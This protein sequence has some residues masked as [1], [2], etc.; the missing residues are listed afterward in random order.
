M[1]AQ[2]TEETQEIGQI[3]DP[4]LPK[5]FPLL[6]LPYA[7]F[8]FEYQ[9]FKQRTVIFAVSFV[10][11]QG[12]AQ[13]KHISD[14]VRAIPKYPELG[15]IQWINYQLLQYPLTF[16]WYSKGVRRQEMDEETGAWYYKGK[17]SD[18]KILDQVCQYYNY[19]SVV[20]FTKRGT[21]YVKGYTDPAYKH[22]NRFY[23]YCHID[24]HEIYKKQ[25]IKFACKNK[26]PNL[27]LGTVAKALL[28]PPE[29]KYNNLTG[30]N[31]YKLPLKLL[32]DYVEQDARLVIKLV[33]NN[34][35]E[36]LD[37]MQMIANIS[38]L[39]FEQ[40]C[41][42]NISTWMGNVLSQY[43]AVEKNIRKKKYTGGHVFEPEIG[44]YESSPIFV[45][46]VKSLYPTMIINYN[47]SPETICCDCC[48]EELSSYVLDEIMQEINSLVGEKRRHCWICKR[49]GI[50]PRWLAKCR[51]ERFKAQKGSIEEKALKIILNGTYG[52]FAN[53]LFKYAD[54][55]VSELTT[56]F[57]RY[58]LR[59]MKKL[60]TSNSYSFRV[61]YGD[62]DSIF[63]SNVASKQHIDDF[64]NE[65][66]K[67]ITNVEIDRKYVIARKLLLRGKKHYIFVTDDN[68]IVSKGNEGGKSDRPPYF[69]K[70]QQQFELDFASGINP[71]INLHKAYMQLEQRKAPLENLA[72]TM[73]LSKNPQDYSTNIAQKLI[74]QQLSALEGDIISFYKGD[75]L[76]KATTKVNEISYSRYI[77]LFRHT[78]EPLVT[79]AGYD[80]EHDVLGV[81]SIANL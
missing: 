1:L 19:P 30:K 44:C 41:A 81:T 49:P 28:N 52:L 60:A 40:T 50:V 76:G 75:C 11:N 37:L 18:L 2:K 17:D 36:I 79:L 62:T 43:N 39:G 15:L 77:E 69:K 54:Y 6:S 4:S 33:Q 23:K 63:L 22:L 32:R 26:Y 9:K 8:D 55:R 31:T 51:E 38:G 70:I 71:T 7:S 57:G 53:K 59:S 3:I 34:N 12:N 66:E 78:F 72:I 14:F 64:L 25:I 56:A 80:F 46:D 29:E 24:L 47:L 5:R 65:W 74:G 73:Q 35:F 42:T 58:I 16:G 68:I 21:P 20:K 48:K 61:I 45:L 13:T 67:T 27:G 10:D